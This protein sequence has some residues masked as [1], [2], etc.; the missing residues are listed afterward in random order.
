LA[1]TW[2]K[3]IHK[4]KGRSVTATLAGSIGYA[5]NPDKT[6]G[7]EF[8]KSYGCD[9]YTA[10]NDFALTK[11]L[12]EQQTG[13]SGRAGDI[14]AYHVR[15]SFKPGEI[16]PEAA[17]E[18]GFA[19]MEKFTHGRHQFVVAVHTDKEHIH[20]HCIFSAANMDCTGKFRNP[21]RSMKIVRQISD[22]L[23]AERGLSI[24]ENPK[25]SRGSYRDWQDKKEPQSNK[26]KLQNLIDSNLSAGMVFEQFIAAMHSAGCEV[27]RGKYLAFK[28]PDAERFIR[29]KSLG[30]D[31]TEE[32]L[33]ERCTGKRTIATK[34]KT[35][36]DA[37]RKSAEYLVEVTKQNTPSLLI[38]VQAKIAAGAGDGYVHWMKIFNLKSAARTLIFLRDNG[39]D[40]Y[41]ELCEKS[42]AASNDFH[43]L[44]DRLKEIE[45]RQQAITELQKNIGT[46][47]K[48]RAAWERY[49]KS[50]YDPGVFEIERAD[51]T[52]HKA[53]KKY[54]DE[55]NFKT[56]LPSINS[57]KQEYA[58]LETERK[59]LYA[60]Y[61]E[62][63]Q[64]YIDLCTAK[65]NA[66]HILGIGKSETERVTER[67][68]KRRS[69]DAR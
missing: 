16:A 4:A 50:G 33:R 1:T 22:F 60:G 58:I 39:I 38:D 49:K 11:Q 65:S 2:I 57:L 64:N 6:D 19:L 59:K 68:P 9:Y 29:V 34:A 32:A 8:V 37:E 35:Y 28:V 12:Y 17:L 55:H 53:A 63:R 18:V 46:Y 62:L 54:F 51:I 24:V 36:A 66:D 45:T 14:L 23:C 31:Y 48:T 69:H 26:N 5:D 47:G 41:D 10:P 44:G 67:E 56:K 21:M 15:Q 27:K 52:L 13:R 61:K 25:P 20:C 3:P 43:K 40:S 7:Y 30:E 42:A